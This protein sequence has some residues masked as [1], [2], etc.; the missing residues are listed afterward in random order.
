LL[1]IVSFSL[2]DV[3]YTGPLAI[4]RFRLKPGGPVESP[5]EDPERADYS[6]VLRFNDP[7]IVTPHS[8]R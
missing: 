2:Y 5:I 4:Y 1:A 6:K 3:C 8:H 7:A